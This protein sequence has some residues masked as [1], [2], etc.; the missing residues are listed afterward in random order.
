MDVVFTVYLADGVNAAGSG[1]AKG[2][3]VAE[4][5]T[6]LAQAVVVMSD[7]E[8]WSVQRPYQY[9]LV[10]EVMIRGGCVHVCVWGGGAV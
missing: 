7:P 8:L 4:N 10:V 1:I 9:T 5:S 3:S 2:V 6:A